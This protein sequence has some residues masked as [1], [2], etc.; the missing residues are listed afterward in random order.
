RPGRIHP[1]PGR[2]EPVTGDGQEVA[3]AIDGLY[4]RRRVVD[5]RGQRADRDVD[6]LP[7]AERR[8]LHEGAF[9]ADEEEPGD[10]AVVQ[11]PVVH[12]RDGSAVGQVFAHSNGQLEPAVILPAQF[13]QTV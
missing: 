11:V 9:A 7:E 4:P 3:E 2:I 8:I 13:G 6:E 12:E 1:Q 10:L 5:G